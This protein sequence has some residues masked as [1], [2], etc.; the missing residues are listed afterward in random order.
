MH[1]AV[2]TWLAAILPAASVSFLAHRRAGN[3]DFA[4]LRDWGRV[5][6]TGGAA[7]HDA[8]PNRQRKELGWTAEG[9]AMAHASTPAHR[10]STSTPHDVLFV[11][12]KF[13]G[14]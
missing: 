11:R 6:G 10:L 2:A 4:F 7:A 1:V 12:P 9:R 5:S 8:G 3:A 14:M 13:S